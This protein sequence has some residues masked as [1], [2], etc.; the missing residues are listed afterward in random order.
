MKWMGNRTGSRWGL[1]LAI[2]ALGTIGLMPQLRADDA[3]GQGAGAAAR[4]SSV[5]GQVRISQGGQVLADPALANTPLFAGTRIETGDDGKAEIQFDDGSVARISPDSALTLAAIGGQG[6]PGS[7]EIVLEGGLA[8]FEM[9]GNGPGGDTRITFGDAVVTATGFTVMRITMDNPPGSLAVFSGNAH[10]QRGNALALDIHGGESVTL[11]G[12]DPS[13]YNLAESIQPDS[14]DQWNSDRDQALSAEATEQTGA[15]GNFIN[16]DNPNSDN[17]NPEWNDLDASGNWYNVPGQGYI[18]S[19]YEA[20]GAGWDPYGCGHW[21]WTPRFGYIWV[22]CESWGYL[23]YSCGSWSFYDSFGWG[24]SPGMGAGMGCRPWWRGG[25][26]AGVNI[27]V[28]PRGYRSIVRPGGPLPGGRGRPPLIGVNRGFSGTTGGFPARNL[29][30]PVEIAGYAVQPLRPLPSHQRYA[31]SASGFVY[32]PAQ[33]Y[34]GTGGAGVD[35]N[36]P[37]GSSYVRPVPGYVTDRRQGYT[38]APTPQYE[39][40]PGQAPAPQNAGA[41]G[42]GNPNSNPVERP[43]NGGAPALG[44]LVPRDYYRT[45]PNPA[46]GQTYTPPSPRGG[47]NGGS[48]N[49]RPANRYNQPNPR[50]AGGS[51]G[52]P[53]SAPAPAPHVSGGAPHGG[54]SGSHK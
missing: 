28:G 23:P 1:G 50:P 46:G 54:S 31:P 36:G 42:N 16:N 13:R 41:P 35:V 48:S 39:A 21:M 44:G 2:L 37:Q 38:P 11:D 7:T 45:H 14:W 9:Q 53:R 47:Y 33:T 17:P 40:I 6:A 34:R 26:Y 32:R 30:T 15:A 10:V 49:E 12:T 8:Y 20:S 43:A 4:L 27:L 5:D 3:T 22:S 19:P 24:W 29:N 25:R 52:A 18:W 51:V